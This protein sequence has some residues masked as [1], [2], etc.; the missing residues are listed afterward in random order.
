MNYFL[1][2][3]RLQSEIVGKK[4]VCGMSLHGSVFEINLLDYNETQTKFNF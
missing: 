3:S 1:A 2:V 4:S